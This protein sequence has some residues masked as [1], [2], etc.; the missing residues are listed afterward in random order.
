[1]AQQRALARQGCRNAQLAGDALDL[2]CALDTAGAAFLRSVST[3]LGWSARSFHRVLRMAR[4]IADL[5]GRPAIAT[6][7][8]AEA[9]QY[10]RALAPG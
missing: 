2:H 8:L 7:D 4:S 9:I 6:A 3:K 10:R 1:V 5:A